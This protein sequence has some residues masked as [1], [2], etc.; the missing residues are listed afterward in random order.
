MKGLH[1]GEAKESDH[2]G[3]G[4]TKYYGLTAAFIS[5]SSA[6]LKEKRVV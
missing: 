2:K 6:S 5:H 3:V 1:A 4:E